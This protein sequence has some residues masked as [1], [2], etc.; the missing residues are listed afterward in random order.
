ML[1]LIH[2]KQI[3]SK[4]NRQLRISYNVKDIF[5]NFKNNVIDRDTIEGIAIGSFIDKYNLTAEWIDEGWIW[6]GKDENGTFLGII[7]RV[8]LVGN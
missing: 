5:V 8:R 2:K 7:G 4:Q 1:D 6:G 3:C